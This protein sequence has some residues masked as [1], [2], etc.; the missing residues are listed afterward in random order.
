[1]SL[2]SKFR[3]RRAIKSKLDEVARIFNTPGENE[4][5]TVPVG[6]TEC[7]IITEEGDIL[8]GKSGTSKPFTEIAPKVRRLRLSAEKVCETLTTR[9]PVAVHICGSKSMVSTYAL[10]AH[11]LVTISPAGI[12][13]SIARIDAALGADGD[14]SKL[15]DELA[16]LLII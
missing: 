4:A 16:R 9:R 1:M 15:V 12:D 6:T 7:A 8:T 13:S 2:I 14:A 3:S 10:G 11:T 5:N